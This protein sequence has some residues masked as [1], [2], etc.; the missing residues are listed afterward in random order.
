MRNLRLSAKLLSAFICIAFIMVFGGIVGWYGFYRAEIALKEAGNLHLTGVDALASIK[1]AQAFACVSERSLLIP[2]F[3]NN[4]ESKKH[5]FENAGAVLKR[6]DEAVGI[7]A[8]LPKSDAKASLWNSA[9][10]SLEVWKKN[11]N[12]YLELAKLGKRDEALALANGLLRNSSLA[13]NKK[14]DDLIA[15]NLKEVKEEESKAEQLAKNIKY[16][17]ICGSAIGIILAIALGMFLPFSIIRPI[18]RTVAGLGDAVDQVVSASLQVASGSQ[19][20]ADGASQQAAAVE[21]TSSSIE[22]MSSMTK[23]TSENAQQASVVLYNDQKASN[24][25]I[26]DKMTLMQE[27][28][29][30]SIHAS[31]ETA[32]IIKTIDEIAFQTNLLALNA[33]VEAA[34]AG[35]AGSG[36]AVVAEEV[37]NLAIRSAESAKNT[38]ALI[39]ESTKNI[40]QSSVLFDEISVELSNNRQTS[41]KL[42]KFA[43]EV[44]TA[45]GEQAQGIEQ[46]N[47]AVLEI[48]RVVQQNAANAEESASVA[49]E[50]TAQAQLMKQYVD[51][52]AR[53]IDGSRYSLS[54]NPSSYPPKNRIMFPNYLSC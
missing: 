31:E 12:R 7:F 39:A 24:L 44:V 50:M 45:S 48:D 18:N 40:K 14:I 38:E 52:L 27:I 20:L 51:E 30:N 49:E 33:A 19:S 46:I 8:R 13:A 21:E 42:A 6:M 1:E 41:K 3:A 28:I 36:F 22:E 15:L 35:E 11:Y 17:V 43:A 10:T 25:S 53:M 29:Y 47:K 4:E 23:Q 34:R 9:N 32:K 16:T 5:Q 26:A 2:E 37:R 54:S